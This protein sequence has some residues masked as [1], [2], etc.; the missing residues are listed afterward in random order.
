MSGRGEKNQGEQ[1]NVKDRWWVDAGDKRRERPKAQSGPV[2]ARF[3]RTVEGY[4]QERAHANLT[5]TNLKLLEQGNPPEGGWGYV[6]LTAAAFPER[7]RERIKAMVALPAFARGVFVDSGR[8]ARL[9]F[10][11]T[12]VGARVLELALGEVPSFDAWVDGEWVRE[13]LFDDAESAIAA[14]KRYVVELLSPVGIARWKEL[15]THV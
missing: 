6:Q 10:T 2:A 12:P 13:E 8:V 15:H 5:D 14:V 11:G 9:L 7:E 1:R 3:Y 4:D